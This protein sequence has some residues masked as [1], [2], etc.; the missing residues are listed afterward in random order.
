MTFTPLTD[1]HALFADTAGDGALT[2]VDGPFS[3]FAAAQQQQRVA[4]HMYDDAQYTVE[5]VCP[6]HP[7]VPRR[8]CCSRANAA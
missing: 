8:V 4:S 7:A 5:P 3:S 6:E 1:P 2:W